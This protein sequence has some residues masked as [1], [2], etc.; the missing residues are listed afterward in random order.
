MAQF[1]MIPERAKILARIPD[2]AV[3]SSPLGKPVKIVFANQVVAAS[4]A[5]LLV[6]ETKHADVVYLPR[7]ALNQTYFTPTD[8]HTYCPFKGHANYWSVRVADQQSDN[9]VWSYEDPYPEVA[10]LKDYVSFYTDRTT[11]MLG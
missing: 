1:S 3:T 8:H 5:A 2:Y 7:A 6:K 10:E 4:D 9:I 11:M